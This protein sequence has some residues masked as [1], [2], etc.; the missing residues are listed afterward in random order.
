MH[1]NGSMDGIHRRQC[2]AAKARLSRN[3]WYLLQ[4]IIEKTVPFAWNFDD[5]EKEFTVLPAA[6]PNLLVNGSTVGLCHRYSSPRWLRLSMEQSTWFDHPT[7]KSG[8]THGIL[9]WSDFPT[10]ELSSKG[11]DEIKRL[12]RTGK[13]AWLFVLRRVEKLKAVKEQIISLRFL[14][15]VIKP[16]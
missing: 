4:D 10:Q 1:S 9:T 15:K 3:C 12:A 8:Q 13:G 7:A 14:M 11:R 16:I 6:F 2:V 5:T